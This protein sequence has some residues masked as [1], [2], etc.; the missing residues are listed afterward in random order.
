M[1]RSPRL[2]IPNA[3]YDLYCRTARGEMVFSKP[4]EARAFVD[5]VADVKQL[6]AFGMGATGRIDSLLICGGGSTLGSTD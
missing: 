1:A 4:D 5:V 2:F 3:I 6:H